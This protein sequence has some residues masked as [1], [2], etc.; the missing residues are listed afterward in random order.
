VTSVNAHYTPRKKESATIA[1]RR[2]VCKLPVRRV[3]ITIVAVEKHQVLRIPE[4]WKEPIIVPIYKMDD[5]TEC[6]NYRGTSLLSTAYKSL[7]NIL[8]SRLSSYEEELIGDHQ[9]GFRRNRS[10]NDHV[11]CILQI[12][13][14]KVG[15]K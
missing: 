1:L 12:P 4:Q 5:T 14:K 7:S 3:G 6:S 13:S 8:L 10:S 15:I 2:S 9:C 11:F